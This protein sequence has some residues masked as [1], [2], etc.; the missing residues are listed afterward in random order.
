[1]AYNV[2]SKDF[3]IFL[4]LD[5]VFAHNGADVGI[6]ECS[7]AGYLIGVPRVEGVVFGDYSCGFHGLASFRLAGIY[8]QM[9]TH[10]LYA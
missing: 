3:L 6:A 10:E 1:M 2:F 7:R 9:D 8:L 5:G 4:P